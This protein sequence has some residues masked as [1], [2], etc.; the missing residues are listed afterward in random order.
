MMPVEDTL[1]VRDFVED[2][3]SPLLELMLSLAE[4]EGYHE[5]F[6]VTES[7]LRSR[8][9]GDDP[10]F[11]ALVAEYSGS[12]GKLAGMAV[13]YFVPY[14]FD[15]RPDLIL[16]ELFVADTVRSAGVGG[17]L[18]QRLTSRARAANCRRIKWLV[19]P[20]NV[21]AKKFYTSLGAK[22]DSSWETWT[23]QLSR[24]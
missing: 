1:V 8:G 2:D 22:H 16:K 12:P 17:A 21:R 10:Q 18:M 7:E 13:Y 9:L 19:L 6:A 4:F 23:M 15:L 11:K 5:Q 14:T 3:V 24:N 20:D